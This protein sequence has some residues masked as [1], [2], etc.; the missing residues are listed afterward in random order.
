ML[1]VLDRELA[2]L[3]PLLRQAVVSRYLQGNSEKQAAERAGCPQGTLGRRASNGIAI[4]RKRLAKRGVV[5][6]GSAL[7]G[8]LTSEAS[9]AIP[10]TLLPSILATVKA[11]AAAGGAGSGGE[12]STVNAD[13]ISNGNGSVQCACCG[14]VLLQGVEERGCEPRSGAGRYSRISPRWMGD[15]G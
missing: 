2:A 3:S 11:A 9:A 12:D 10:E 4:L 1:Q 5:V 8:L 6:G 7:V 15:R 14:Y 13:Y